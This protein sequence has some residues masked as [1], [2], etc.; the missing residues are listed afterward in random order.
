MSAHIGMF[1]RV[2][3]AAILAAL[4]SGRA[5]EAPPVWHLRSGQTE[6][7]VMRPG[8]PGSFYQGERFDHSGIVLFLSVERVVVSKWENCFRKEGLAGLEERRRS[9][10]PPVVAQSTKATMAGHFARLR[11]RGRRDALLTGDVQPFTAP[12]LSPRTKSF[13]VNRK[14]MISGMLAMKNAAMIWPHC[15]TYSP[16]R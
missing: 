2:L 5:S 9:G 11:R 1:T 14:R 10:R 3:L 13:I 15:F 16:S 4:P 8:Q 7:V 12:L 6:A